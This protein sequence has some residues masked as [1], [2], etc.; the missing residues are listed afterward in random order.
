MRQATQLHA[1]GKLREAEAIYR[2]VLQREPMNAE[3]MHHLGLIAH[4]VGQ[5][6]PAIELIR[7]SISIKP[8][9]GYFFKNLGSV[10]TAVGKYSE[11]VEAFETAVG[12]TPNDATAHHPLGV[13]YEKMYEY[14]R[15]RAAYRRAIELDPKHAPSYFNLGVIAEY[16]GEYDESLRLLEKAIDL[17][18]DYALARTSRAT[19]LLRLER[20]EE[21]WREYEWRWRLPQFRQDAPDPR[22]PVWDGEEL[23]GKTILLR[24]EQGMGDT[25]Q[26]VR[27]AKLVKERGAGRVILLSQPAL[28]RLMKRA[29]GVDEVVGQGSAIP[30]YDVQVPL[31][32]LPRI[33]KTEMG[34]IPADVPYVTAEP[35]RVAAWREKLGGDGNLNVGLVWSSNPG[36]PLARFRTTTLAA[37]AP[38]ARVEGVMFYSLQKGEPGKQAANA[39]EGM[40]LVNY[41]RELTD[42][43]ETAALMENLDAVVTVDTAVAH[44]AGAI[45]ARTLTVVPFLSDF[46]W[47]TNRDDSPWYPTMR[48]FRLRSMYGWREAIERAAEAL[49]ELVK[50]RMV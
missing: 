45:G 1:Q 19:D 10:L 49:E 6:G 11:A 44:L 30:A 35:D 7:K 28:V 3:A 23:A 50:A 38:L 42:F 27:Y 36:H 26:F 29:V 17:K 20:F 24:C 25:I 4:Q 46:R 39:P 47:F 9:V 41:T 22:K 34:T 48:L 33:F 16:H 13:A 8:G 12:L 37:F 31:L 21:G 15:A 32:S 18:S 14:E 5:H 43:S 40:R 2:Q